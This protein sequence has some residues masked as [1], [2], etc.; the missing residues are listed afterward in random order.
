MSKM[1][2]KI[3]LDDTSGCVKERENGIAFSVGP[4]VLFAATEAQQNAG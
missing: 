1:G 2:W 4:Y 3:V